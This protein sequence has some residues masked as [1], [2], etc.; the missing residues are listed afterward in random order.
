MTKVFESF[1]L[2]AFGGFTLIFS[3]CDKS[4][5]DYDYAPNMYEATSYKAQKEDKNSPDGAAARMPPDG[6]IPRGYEPYKYEVSE[7]EKAG[8]E[9]KNPLPPSKAVL[10]RGQKIYMTF[11]V[12]CHG[13][14]ADGAGY[15]VPPYV[16]P[17]ALISE[18]VSRWADGNIF[19]VITRGQNLMPSYASQIV[20]EDRWAI[21]HYV[22][23]LQ[24][25][26]NQAAEAGKNTELTK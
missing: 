24:R 16:K 18:K 1:A 22:R 20:I 4:T 13:P 9:L 12:V 3:G 5:P 19:H 6:T 7:N 2:I 8:K 17:P 11:C 23:V 15:I 14:K 25:A 10:E 26:A 21:I